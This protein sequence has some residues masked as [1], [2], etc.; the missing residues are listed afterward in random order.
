MAT[1]S[2]SQ[3]PEL[4]LSLFNHAGSE[5][6]ERRM[7]DEGDVKVKPS[8]TDSD[9]LRIARHSGSIRNGAAISKP[10]ICLVALFLCIEDPLN[11]NV[12]FQAESSEC[13]LV[14]EK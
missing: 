2:T 10:V 8:E 9:S 4:R 5:G 3:E 1:E 6:A 14:G 12:A 13:L 7:C 11:A